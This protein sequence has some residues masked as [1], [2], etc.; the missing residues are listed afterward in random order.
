MNDVL[1]SIIFNKSVLTEDGI[2]RPLHSAISQGEGDF[3]QEMIRS[4]QPQVSLEVGCAYG[5]SSLFICEA[6]REVGADK[7]IV[8][9]PY[10]H[11]HWEG[12]GLANLRRAGY[13]DIIDFHEVESYQYL[14][15]LTEEHVTIDFA[16]IDGQHTFDYVLVDFFLIDKLLKPGGIII[17]DDFLYPSIRSVCRYVLLNLRYKCIS[18]PSRELPELAAS[19]RLVSRVRQQGIGPLVRAPLSRIIAPAWQMLVWHAGQYW[20]VL[21]SE[22]F[23]R[24]PGTDLGLP[25]YLNHVALQKLEHDLI[26]KGPDATRHW[27][28][29]K[30]F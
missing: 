16:F 8:I 12:I 14:S 7:H 1:R 13:D 10:Q 5:V 24:T 6:L 29:H 20:R 28:T 17:F 2:T 25:E 15:R 3:I 21:V 23:R 4:A 19:R 11:S 27:T 9:D 18:P 30:P 22:P 26:G